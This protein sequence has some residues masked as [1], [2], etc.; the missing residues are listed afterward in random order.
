[1]SLRTAI[2][3][4]RVLPNTG[5]AKRLRGTGLPPGRTEGLDFSLSHSYFCQD[6]AWSKIIMSRAR[7]HSRQSHPGA[8]RSAID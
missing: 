7:L 1:V 6:A 8:G 2:A 5:L 3:V 4:L